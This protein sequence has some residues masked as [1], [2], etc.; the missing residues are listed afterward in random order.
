M[1]STRCTAI[2]HSGHLIM[3]YVHFRRAIPPGYR[4]F[5]IPHN[6]GRGICLQRSPWQRRRGLCLAGCGAQRGAHVHRIGE[7]P[8]SPSALPAPRLCLPSS[9][10]L[11]HSIS[12]V[13]SLFPAL[14]KHVCCVCFPPDIAIFGLAN[15]KR[16]HW[17]A[18]KK[19][20]TREYVFLPILIPLIPNLVTV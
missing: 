16:K 14:G 8:S 7:S 2:T 9:T 11:R 3:S 13:R 12:S 17:S 6:T 4:P 10:P 15:P 1:K 18:A 19:D 5:V 20:P